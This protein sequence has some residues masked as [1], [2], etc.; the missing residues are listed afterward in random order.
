MPVFAYLD[1]ASASL[2]ISA[3][4]GAF[5][6]IALFFRAFWHRV[7]GAVTGGNRETADAEPQNLPTD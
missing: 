7:K 2:I 5:A 4:V 6:G 1:P 3:I